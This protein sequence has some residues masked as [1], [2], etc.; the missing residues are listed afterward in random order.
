MLKWFS[1]NENQT[2]EWAMVVLLVKSLEILNTGYY[3]IV[4]IFLE[5]HKVHFW[6]KVGRTANIAENS[7]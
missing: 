6:H 4:I 7:G 1:E 3:G 5:M 2:I